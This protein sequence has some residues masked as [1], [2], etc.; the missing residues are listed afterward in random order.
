PRI[1]R[2]FLPHWAEAHAAHPSGEL[3]DSRF[4][5][6]QRLHGEAPLRSSAM[7]KAEAQKRPLPCRRHRAF[8]RVDFEFQPRRDEERDARHHAMSRSGAANVHITVVRIT[9]E[10]MTAAFELPINA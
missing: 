8:R 3:P 7:R 4:E 5:P 1:P 10:A 6:V 9:Y 2:K